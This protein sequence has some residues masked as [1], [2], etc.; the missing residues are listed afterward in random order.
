MIYIA[1]FAKHLT[2]ENTETKQYKK[3]IISK[4]I[5][6]YFLEFPGFP[7]VPGVPG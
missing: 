5:L 2:T 1:G 6:S 4:Q 7:G 3:T